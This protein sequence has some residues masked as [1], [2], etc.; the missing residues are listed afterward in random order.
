[1]SINK[2]HHFFKKNTQTFINKL[3]LIIPM[4]NS[5]DLIKNIP[6]EQGLNYIS[7]VSETITNKIV[8]FLSSNGFNVSVRWSSLLL[9]FLSLSIFYIGIKISKPLIK[10]TLIILGFIILLGLIMPSW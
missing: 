9:M 6:V 3:L 5:T 1:M 4:S 7:Y 2:F 8:E 10:W